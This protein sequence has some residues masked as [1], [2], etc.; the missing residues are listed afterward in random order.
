MLVWG[1][2]YDSKIPTMPPP[3]TPIITP[4]NKR[5]LIF[6]IV[7]LHIDKLSVNMMIQFY[8]KSELLQF[9]YRIWVRNRD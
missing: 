5:L 9:M 3:P 6:A 1:R 7:V 2:I 4:I 8:I